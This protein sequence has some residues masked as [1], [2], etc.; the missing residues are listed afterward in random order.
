[1]PSR[2][3][4]EPLERML[5]DDPIIRAPRASQSD[6]LPIFVWLLF[7]LAAVIHLGLLGMT[8]TTGSRTVALAADCTR[9]LLFPLFGIAFAVDRFCRATSRR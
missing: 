8:F 3:R 2:H 4:E 9:A 7:I 6:G 5:D 1:M